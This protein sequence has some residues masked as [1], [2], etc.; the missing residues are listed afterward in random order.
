MVLADLIYTALLLG[1]FVWMER[2]HP[3]LQEAVAK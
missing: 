1:T 2:R 3:V